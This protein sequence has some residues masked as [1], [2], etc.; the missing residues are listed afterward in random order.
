MSG[1]S[2]EIDGQLAVTFFK[3]VNKELIIIIKY[4]K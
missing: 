4:F 3:V 2:H 1:R